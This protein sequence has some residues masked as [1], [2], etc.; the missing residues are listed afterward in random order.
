MY[1]LFNNP[2][3][4]S[5]HPR[6]TYQKYEYGL[7]GLHKDLAVVTQYNRTY[8]R[9]VKSGH[10][11][12]KLIQNLNLNLTLDLMVFRDRVEEVAETVSSVMRMTSSLYKGRMFEPGVFY[13][14]G[15]KEIIIAHSTDFNLKNIEEEWEDYQP[16]T[17]LH[18]PKTDLHLDTPWGFQN[19]AEMGLSVV[20]VNIPMLAC[21]YLMWRRREWLLNSEAQRTTT[22]FVS[23]YPLTNSLHSQVDIAILNRL[24]RVYQG[25]PVG[26]S[27]ISRSYTTTDWSSYIDDGLLDLTEDLR[28]RKL[29]FDEV[30]LSIKGVSHK[31]IREVCMIPEMAPT[32]Q[33]VWALT[34]ARV[35]LVTFLLEWNKETH[36][37]RNI[38]YLNTIRLDAKRLLNDNTLNNSLPTAEAKAWIAKLENIL[39]LV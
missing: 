9:A 1:R 33:V 18:H 27:I 38:S 26:S 11:L 36:S 35:E 34:L 23:S 7:R 8:P 6:N 30:L 13:G 19:N 37:N 15:S 14:P 32:Q 20:L 3:V 29:T 5:R 28:S 16:V 4:V 10:F 17:F 39:A 24:Q 31:S 2:T 12:V 22:Q 25:K 21:Q